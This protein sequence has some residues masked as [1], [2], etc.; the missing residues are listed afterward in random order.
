M[1]RPPRRPLVLQVRLAETAVR[2]RRVSRVMSGPG[3]LRTIDGGRK[4]ATAV[5]E[6]S[7]P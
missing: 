2:I 7:H 4:I 6:E 5:A 1:T 3:K